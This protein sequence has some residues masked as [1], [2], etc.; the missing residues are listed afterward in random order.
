MSILEIQDVSMRFGGLVAVSDFNL[1]LDKGDLVGLIGPNGSGKTTVFNIISGFYEPTAGTVYFDGRDTA[2]LRPDERVALGMARIFQNSRLFG[3]LT[4]LDNIMVSYHVRLRSS[5]LGAIVRTPN[6][7]H[8][9]RQAHEE[10]VTL[11][12]QLGL[13]NVIHEQAASL[14]YGLQR[15]VEVA[16][17]LATKPQLLLLDEPTTGLSAEETSEMMDFIL[18]IRSDFELT[19]LLIEHTMRV[20]MGC[21]PRILVLNYGRTIAQG[22]PGEIQGNPDVIQAYLGEDGNA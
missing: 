19:V 8:Q 15:K 7:V 16:R 11:L 18:A 10:S 3:S 14:P 12:A 21:C 20:V 4:V 9:E 17:A 6:Y 2:G 1:W 13:A 5:L 22:T